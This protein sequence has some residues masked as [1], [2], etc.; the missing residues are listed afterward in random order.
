MVR[1]FQESRPVECPGMSA[2]WVGISETPRMD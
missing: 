2:R 1:F